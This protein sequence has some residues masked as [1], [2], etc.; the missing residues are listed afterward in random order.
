MIFA[1]IHTDRSY[2]ELYPEL[3]SYITE[4]YSNVE[5][6]VQGDAY[7]WIFLNDEKVA[8][9]TFSSMQFQVKAGRNG[10][11]LVESVINYLKKK[12]SISAYNPPLFD[13]HES[14]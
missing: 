14:V 1:E 5:S 3:L 7:I 11:V 9:D 4:T 2:Y 12:Y 13:P 6:G 8:L 10:G